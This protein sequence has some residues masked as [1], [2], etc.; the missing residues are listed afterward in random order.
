MKTE[1]K[2]ILVACY[3]GNVAKV[4]SL[5]S[6]NA[7]LAKTTD[8]DGAE[9]EKGSSTLTLAC[10]GGSLEIVKLLVNAGADLDAVG[11]DGTALLS[12]SFSGQLDIVRYLLDRGADPNKESESG[13]SAL[14]AA[15][16]RGHVDVC[17]LL[18]LK[19]AEINAQTTQG[20]TD[21]ISTSPPVCG[22]TPLHLAVAKGS[23]DVVSLLLQKG[24]DKE[25]TDHIGQKPIHWAG[26]YNRREM[27]KLL[28]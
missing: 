25:V 24:A 5:L 4:K 22:E 21:L 3:Q 11:K 16:L 8:F 12:A 23:T 20:T 10:G 19:G 28:E 26:R 27:I 2:Q 17:N 14:H 13:E 7:N 9:W 1:E 18:V 15:A 6:Q